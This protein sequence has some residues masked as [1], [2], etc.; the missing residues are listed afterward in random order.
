MSPV[1]PGEAGNIGVDRALLEVDAGVNE[2]GEQFWYPAINMSEKVV[3]MAVL[4]ITL[5]FI[6][7]YPA[8]DRLAFES[9]ILMPREIESLARSTL[10]VD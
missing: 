10:P 1:E 2:A 8:K 9:P 7:L 3:P 5:I 4:K 6:F